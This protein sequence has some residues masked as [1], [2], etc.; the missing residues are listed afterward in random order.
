MSISEICQIIVSLGF[1]ATAS[2]LCLHS[3]FLY[4]IGKDLSDSCGKIFKALE[5]INASSGLDTHLTEE[6]TPE[7]RPYLKGNRER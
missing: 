3:R 1:L 2:V 4:W 7:P 6:T 5:R